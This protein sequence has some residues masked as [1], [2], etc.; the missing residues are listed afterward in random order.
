MLVQRVEEGFIQRPG[1][2][3]GMPGRPGPAETVTTIAELAFRES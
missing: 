3:V 2:M 1:T